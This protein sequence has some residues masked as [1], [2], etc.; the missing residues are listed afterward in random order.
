MLREWKKEDRDFQHSMM[1]HGLIALIAILGTLFSVG[2]GTVSYVLSH[3][4]EKVEIVSQEKD[5]RGLTIVRF[6][7]PERGD[8][9]FWV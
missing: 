2:C 9:L 4:G 1:K 8:V 7:L 3:V 5:D 6:R